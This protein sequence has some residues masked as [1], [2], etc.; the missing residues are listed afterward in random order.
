[1]PNPL[2]LE[3]LCLAKLIVNL[4]E[5]PSA[6]LAQLPIHLRRL[7]LYNI[8]AADICRLEQTDVA[9][10]INITAVWKSLCESHITFNILYDETGLGTGILGD[11][12]KSFY[13]SFISLAFLNHLHAACYS[14]HASQ[15]LEFLFSIKS[16]LSIESCNGIC[17]AHLHPREQSELIVPSHYAAYFSST[18]YSD[19]QLINI[20]LET[21]HY[22][23]SVLEV[24]CEK[25][26]DCIQSEYWSSKHRDV[27]TKFLSQVQ[28]LSISHHGEDHSSASIPAFIMN[29]LSTTR[30][31]LESLS[32]HCT[33]SSFFESAMFGFASH[34]HDSDCGCELKSL[35]CKSLHGTADDSACFE[36]AEVI[37]NHPTLEN[38]S[39]DFYIAP[40]ISVT[41]PGHNLLYQAL[42]T[43][44]NQSKPHFILL[45]KLS[46]TLAS[47]Q[48]IIHSFLISPCEDKQALVLAQLRILSNSEVG[49]DKDLS[50]LGHS[51]EGIVH[52]G[53]H[54]C[55]SDLPP[56]LLRW[57]SEHAYLQ[58]NTLMVSNE[59]GY[60][61][62]LLHVLLN[63]SRLEVKCLSM[64]G[65]VP[66]PDLM[67]PLP[68][69]H[70]FQNPTLKELEFSS[71]DLGT[72]GCIF[73]FVCGINKQ[74]LL[75]SLL[76]LDIS[77]NQLG[78][79][80]DAALQLL[81]EALVS[82]P[83]IKSFELQM[84]Y[85]DFNKHHLDLLR[86]IWE[87]HSGGKKFSKLGCY[88][89][90]PQLQPADFEG[91][92]DLTVELDC[93]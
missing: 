19:V 11:R 27:I 78:E 30:L 74:A 18:V 41:S 38:V 92:H 93:E 10:N 28:K 16:C 35:E 3:T 25:F 2:T 6:S 23:P 12:G 85:N 17:H 73:E 53:L 24:V 49:F 4:D 45:E 70:L 75:G 77:Y 83:Q 71:A 88:E 81:F 87:E 66:L 50:H 46:I 60:S 54:L 29:V 51:T 22:F 7:L 14:T 5:F 9:N 42:A 62:D 63:H 37:Q 82:L 55:Y 33:H 86:E 47:L 44:N 69:N 52:K 21:T 26:Y 57:L 90:E 61:N 67:H 15:V 48:R 32:I 20:I 40:N 65:Y 84:N 79:A 64:S 8:P 39:L 58:L 34:L 1:M 31:K 68:F 43:L 13:F 59:E 72:C 56:V 80:P 76:K 89:E 91:L 36:L